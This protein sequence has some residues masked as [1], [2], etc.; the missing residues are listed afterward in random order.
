MK[1]GRREARRSGSVKEEFRAIREDERAE[2][3]RLWETVFGDDPAYFRRYFYGDTE[4]LP[5]YTQVAKMDGKIVS[6]AHV[7]KRT[8]DCGEMK[9]TMGGL[10][11]VATLPEYRGRGLNRQCV[12]RLIA[13]MEAD[14]MDFSLLFTGVNAYYAKM[15]Y[16]NLPRPDATLVIRPD[17]APVATN[18]AVRSA[19][20]EDLPFL[21]A[22]YAAY[23]DTRPIA[24]KRSD[25]Y[26]RDWIGISPGKIPAALLVALDAENALM[27]YIQVDRWF[28]AQNSKDEEGTVL[29]FALNPFLSGEWKETAAFALLQEATTR[30]HAAGISQIY[31]GLSPDAAI[32]NAAARLFLER[33]DSVEGDGMVRL[34]HRENLFRGLSMTWNERWNGAG[35]PPGTIAFETPYGLTE[36]D[37]TGAFLK[38]AP[39]EQAASVISQSDF[40]RL[41]FGFGRLEVLAK[42]GNYAELLAGL[43]PP[44][45]PVYWSA[46]GF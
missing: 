7:V 19:R 34:L 42:S 2:C 12:E 45:A 43:F 10:A 13:I 31:S 4:W 35:N 15:G 24:V 36:L 16:A 6:A 11:N 9:L 17:F 3:L 26:W 40:F 18:C 20:D 46:D 27:G 32:A 25:A 30:F 41:L 28:D 39:V 29:E 5:Y 38:I 33:I 21:Y 1:R 8:V 44:Q 23:N 14:A 22:C 37:A